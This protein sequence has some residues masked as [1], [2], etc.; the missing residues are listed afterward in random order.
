[1]HENVVISRLGS[2]Q[3]CARSLS[4]S[5]LRMQITE[6]LARHSVR[7]MPLI[8]HPIHR[9]SGSLYRDISTEDEMEETNNGGREG[10]DAASAN[11]TPFL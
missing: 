1:M 8:W 7:V 2:I 10:G 5:A 6:L 3:G 4:R 11:P 9:Y